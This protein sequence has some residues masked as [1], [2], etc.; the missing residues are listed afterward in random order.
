MLVD[1]TTGKVVRKESAEILHEFS[2]VFKQLH[3]NTE[4]DLYPEHLAGQIDEWNEK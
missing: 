3:K 1:V 4:V 2:T